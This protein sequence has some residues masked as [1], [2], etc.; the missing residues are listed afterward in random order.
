MESVLPSCMCLI[1]LTKTQVVLDQ[2]HP[3]MSFYLHY[4]F[5]NLVSNY[6]HVLGYWESELQRM[7][8][9]VEEGQGTILFT[10]ESISNKMVITDPA[11]ATC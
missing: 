6:S 9:G 8:S 2:V 10:S 1:F 7:N 3:V 11:Q 4:C 5:A